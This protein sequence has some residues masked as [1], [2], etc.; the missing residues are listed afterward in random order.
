MKCPKCNLEMKEFVTRFL[1]RNLECRH[2]IRKKNYKKLNK[3]DGFE[4]DKD[5]WIK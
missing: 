4:T 1:C 5:Y 2:E 3:M